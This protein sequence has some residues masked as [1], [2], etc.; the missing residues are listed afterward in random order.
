MYCQRIKSLIKSDLQSYMELTKFEWFRIVQQLT[1]H[2][3]GVSLKHSLLH[4][5]LTYWPD[6][7]KS[8]YNLWIVVL[9]AFEP[10]KN[11]EIKYKMSILKRSSLLLWLGD[12]VHFPKIY[13]HTSIWD[14]WIRNKISMWST[15]EPSYR[16]EFLDCKM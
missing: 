12:L 8:K 3:L 16:C 14:R 6:S 15:F 1:L 10:V 7:I 11:E 5:K 13:Q 4:V 2:N 9:E